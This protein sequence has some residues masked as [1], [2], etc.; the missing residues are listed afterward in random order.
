MQKPENLQEHFDWV[1]ENAEP[2]RNRQRGFHSQVRGYF[3]FH[4]LPE[5]RVLEFGCGKGDLLASLNPSRGVGVDLSPKMVA[6]AQERH[7]EDNLEFLQ[8]DLHDTDLDEVFDVIILDYLIGYLHDVHQCISNLKKFCHT[9]TRIYI[10][11]LN[12]IWDPLLKGARWLRLTSPQ[13]VS[14]WLGSS[15]IKN[16]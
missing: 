14:N 10:V 3:Q 5:M 11:S 12:H 15:D 2:Y 6:A 4:V 1:A 7:G 16:V 9:R 13:P 8:G